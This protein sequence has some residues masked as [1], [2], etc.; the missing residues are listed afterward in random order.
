[1][2]NEPD[3]IV[4]NKNNQEIAVIE[5]KDRSD[6][7]RYDAAEMYKRF[8]KYSVTG[9]PEY[10]LLV[11]RDKVSLWKGS[12]K[13]QQDL[14]VIEF[15]TEPILKFYEKQMGPV[16]KGTLDYLVFQ[17][18]MDMTNNTGPEVDQSE[19]FRNFK[20][21]IQDSQVRFGARG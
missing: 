3:I 6:A 7:N 19:I 13:I 2:S 4:T 20:A 17:W 15:T 10:F 9:N 11:T 21:E 1:V 14:A 16:G 18:L 5:V 12:I 8:R